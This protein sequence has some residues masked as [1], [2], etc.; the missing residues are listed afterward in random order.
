MKFVWADTSQG[1]RTETNNNKKGHGIKFPLFFVKNHISRLFSPVL[2]NAIL[3]PICP[4][5]WLYLS[6]NVEPKQS[7]H[8]CND[9]CGHL[10]PLMSTELV[11][12][13]TVF[14]L[15]QKRDK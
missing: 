11:P 7:S 13:N 5:V 3:Y 6:C 8:H 1:T 9:L 14:L 4:W 12:Y 10:L 15:R 2:L